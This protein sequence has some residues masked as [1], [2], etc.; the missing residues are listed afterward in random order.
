MLIMIS[1]NRVYIFLDELGKNLNI[2]LKISLGDLAKQNNLNSM[3]KILFLW[4]RR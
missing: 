3:C 4:A 2:A 1:T